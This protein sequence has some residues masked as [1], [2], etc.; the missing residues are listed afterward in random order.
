MTAE[1]ITEWYRC[2]VCKKV[3]PSQKLLCLAATKRQSDTGAGYYTLAEHIKKIHDLGCFPININLSRLD[4]G[5]GMEGSFQEN[6]NK[7]KQENGE[8]NGIKVAT[9]C[10]MRRSIRERKKDEVMSQNRIQYG[11]APGQ[12]LAMFLKT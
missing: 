7:W 2:V 3:K 4:E 10:S 1:D 12:V 6:G 11:S 5:N 8:Q 9:Y